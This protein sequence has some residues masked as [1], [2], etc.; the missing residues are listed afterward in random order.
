M[1]ITN[2]TKRRGVIQ[3]TP[4]SEERVY[5]LVITFDRERKI[6][7]KTHISCLNSL[8]NDTYLFRVNRDQV[9][10]N[11]KTPE[12]LI[13]KLADDLGKYLY[14][15]ELAVDKQGYVRDIVNHAALVR[16]WEA[17]KLKTER[18]YRGAVAERIC[19]QFD[20]D[21]RN[22][23]KFLQALREDWFF[24][25]Y[26]SG[27]YG[28]GAY[29]FRNRTPVDLPLEPGSAPVRCY[30]TRE[31]SR[32]SEVPGTILIDCKGHV[33]DQAIIT[34]R[35]PAGNN[36]SVSG[37]VNDRLRQSGGA[38]RMRY[39][40]YRK[41]FSVRSIICESGFDGADGAARQ[42]LVEIYHQSRE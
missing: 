42:V 18:Y 24:A 20:Q 2:D 14:P 35:K 5:G 7:F 9:Y 39:R 10:I 15:I 8:D 21:I 19:R 3:F 38:V 36:V 30:L 16:N 40:L 34:E 22:K 26:F 4:F 11:N 37:P 25:V 29:D 33:G 6:H 12:Q 23:G 13:D 32:A 31:I 1:D 28:L 27:I 17:N 41:D